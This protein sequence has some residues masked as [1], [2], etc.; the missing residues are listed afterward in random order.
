MR[1]REYASRCSLDLGACDFPSSAVL[2]LPRC[3]I[4]EMRA[5][6]LLSSRTGADRRS[7]AGHRKKLAPLE[8]RWSAGP[9]IA[10]GGGA[11]SFAGVN[12][13]IDQ[14]DFLQDGECV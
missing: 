8:S 7:A 11:Q 13:G 10:G 9:T 4:F 14:H 12:E 1:S 3:M 6:S 2:R 5:S